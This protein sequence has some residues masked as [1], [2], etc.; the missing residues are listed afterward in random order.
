VVVDWL[1]GD[2]WG[3]VGC[4][5]T[6]GCGAA[7][8]DAFRAVRRYAC[9]HC[10]EWQVPESRMTGRSVGVCFDRNTPDYAKKLCW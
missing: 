5:C 7:C 9:T 6:V 8:F 1:G 3:L 4:G 10:S 2:S